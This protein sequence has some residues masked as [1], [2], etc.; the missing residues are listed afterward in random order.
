[1]IYDWWISIRFVGVYVLSF[2]ACD[3]PILGTNRLVCFDNFCDLS[4][5]CHFKNKAMS[6][7]FPRQKFHSPSLFLSSPESF[8]V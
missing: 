2:V 3:R 1:M 7:S 8:S 6:A 5:S 4:Y